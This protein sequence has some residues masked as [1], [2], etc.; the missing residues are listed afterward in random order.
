[1]AGESSESKSAKEGR[2]DPFRLPRR[3]EELLDEPLPRFLRRKPSAFRPWAFAPW[4]L[5]DWAH[6]E[7]AWLPP[8]DVIEKDGVMTIRADLPG[9]KVEDVKVSARGTS[10]IIEGKREEAQDLHDEDFHVAERVSGEF[11]R[12]VSIPEGID[13]GTIQASY[14]DGVL[15][16]RIPLGV[17]RTGG[18]TTVKVTAH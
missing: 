15:D 5:R 11:R 4:A 12:T 8:I 17:K 3:L 13:A 14:P 9:V 16:V 18:S 7:D 1:M 2:R 10:L 6:D